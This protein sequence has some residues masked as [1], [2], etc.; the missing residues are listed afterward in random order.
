MLLL[1]GVIVVVLILMLVLVYK[2]ID[3]AQGPQWGNDL[4]NSVS[5][6]AGSPLPDPPTDI[7]MDRWMSQLFPWIKS[8]KL[9]EITMPGSHDSL[10]YACKKGIS[11]KNQLQTLSGIVRAQDKNLTEQMNLGARYFDLRFRKFGTHYVGHHGAVNCTDVSLTDVMQNLYDFLTVPEHLYEVVIVKIDVEDK[12]NVSENRDA[13]AAE[14]IRVLGPIIMKQEPNWMLP[15]GQLPL[16]GTPTVI[17]FHAPSQNLLILWSTVPAAFA[18]SNIKVWDPYD[19]HV[20]YS[21]N[22]AMWWNRLNQIYSHGRRP[23]SVPG[24][25]WQPP[26]LA[27]LQWISSGAEAEKVLT[28][29]WSLLSNSKVMNEYLMSHPVEPPLNMSSNNVI[30][31]DGI[32]A[33]DAGVKVMS[34]IV[35]QNITNKSLP[36]VVS[37]SCP[38]VKHCAEC[39]PERGCQLCADGFDLNPATGECELTNNPWFW[40]SIL[41]TRCYCSSNCSFR[42]KGECASIPGVQQVNAQDADSFVKNGCLLGCGVDADQLGTEPFAS[43]VSKEVQDAALAG[44]FKGMWRNGVMAG[45]SGHNNTARVLT[46]SYWGHD[47]KSRGTPGAL[48]ADYCIVKSDED[49]KGMMMNSTNQIEYHAPVQAAIKEA[50]VV[51]NVPAG[52]QPYPGTWD[53]FSGTPPPAKNLTDC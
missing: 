45:T 32:G 44:E 28:F 5:A 22:P 19:S 2:S 10:S 25:N 42:E 8:K 47:E 6:T 43:L 7:K 13:V 49:C 27:V 46:N 33:S 9:W 31:V 23:T 15:F 3:H 14:L 41:G 17:P 51:K 52:F 37:S 53:P 18:G 38:N 48:F 29:G 12:N 50:C 21:G 11:D 40:S 4:R 39:T 36:Q 1:S 16:N 35:N 20:D 26:P 34:W 24:P 30:M